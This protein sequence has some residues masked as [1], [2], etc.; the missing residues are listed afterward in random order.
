MQYGD[1]Y[2][3]VLSQGLKKV[4][5]IRKFHLQDNRISE[6]SAAELVPIISKNAKEVNLATNS[7]GKIGC[8]NLSRALSEP[9]CQ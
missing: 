2:A 7:I 5:S 1:Q 3:S 9:K 6:K 8:E 4:G